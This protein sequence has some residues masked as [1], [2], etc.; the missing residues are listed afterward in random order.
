[1]GGAA[2]AEDGS[3]SSA[4]DDTS[5]NDQVAHDEIVADSRPQPT[6]VDDPATLTG[7]NVTLLLIDLYFCVQR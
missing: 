4:T 2:S 5:D 1:M 7:E 3:A 6:V